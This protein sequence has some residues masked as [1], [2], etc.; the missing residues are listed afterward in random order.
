MENYR[1]WTIMKCRKRMKKNIVP[2]KFECEENRKRTIPQ[3]EIEAVLKK[4]RQELVA[5]YLDHQ[6][7]TSSAVQDEEQESVSTVWVR[8]FKKDIGVQV[9]IKPY[10]RSKAIQCVVQTPIVSQ[11]CSPMSIKKKMW[12]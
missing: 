1:E 5:E 8:P 10:F 9:H 2:H 11:S 12:L 7:S 6:P 3:A 4:R